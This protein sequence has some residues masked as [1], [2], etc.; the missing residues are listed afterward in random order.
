MNP[1]LELLDAITTIMLGA[2]SGSRVGRIGRAASWNREVGQPHS[3]GVTLTRPS[4][5]PEGRVVV[6]ASLG[7]ARVRAGA[8]EGLEV[9]VAAPELEEANEVMEVAL[10]SLS[11]G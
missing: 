1:L 5:L 6:D 2:E 10:Q 7:V 3:V 9:H 4:F 11:V 8:Q